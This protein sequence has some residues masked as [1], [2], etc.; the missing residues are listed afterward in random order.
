VKIVG[1]LRERM[2][3]YLADPE[4]RQIIS[5]VLKESKTATTIRTEL[6]LPASSVYRKISEL[7]ECGLLMVDRF[8]IRQ[9]GKREALYSCSFAEI[10]LKVESGALELEVVPSKR[11]LEKRWFELFLSKTTTLADRDSSV[12]ET[13]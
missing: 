7:R 8:L 4:S 5:S 6:N 3:A 13:S 11:S 10:G 9:D 1:D 2:I 12:P